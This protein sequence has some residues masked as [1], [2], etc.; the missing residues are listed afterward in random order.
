[1][2][3]NADPLSAEGGVARRAYAK[4]AALARSLGLPPAAEELARQAADVLLAGRPDGEPPSDFQE[5]TLLALVAAAAR[6]RARGIR[7]RGAERAR[8]RALGSATSSRNLWRR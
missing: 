2:R 8:A 3:L 7:A 5:Y 6:R 4:L 1:M